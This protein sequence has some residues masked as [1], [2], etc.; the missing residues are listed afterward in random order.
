MKHLT[1]LQPALMR[2]QAEDFERESLRKALRD[3]LTEHF[4]R[5]VVHF[6]LAELVYQACDIS[7]GFPGFI[8]L[9]PERLKRCLGS[10]EMSLQHLRCWLWRVESFAR[11]VQKKVEEGYLSVLK[12]N[13]YLKDIGSVDIAA[14]QKNFAREH[15]WRQRRRHR[16]STS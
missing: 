16:S 8:V 3:P 1:G 14:I 13:E 9:T 11:L 10:G 15:R 7:E 12:G 4:Q 2:Q 5:N 6:H